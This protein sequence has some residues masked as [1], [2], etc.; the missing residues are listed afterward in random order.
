MAKALIVIPARM[1]STRFSGK[2]MAVIAGKSMIERVWRIAKA[3]PSAARAIIA[4]DDAEL[5]TFCETF[6][7]E[8]MMT[9]PEC[10]TGTDRVAEVAAALPDYDIIFN[11]QGDAVLTPPAVIET[12]IQA[13]QADLAAPVG[14]PVVHLK[15]EALEGFLEKKKAGSTTGTTAVF[16]LNGYALYFSK[17]VIPNVRGK[18]EHPPIFKHVGL[19]AYRREALAKLASLPEGR[20]EKA[21]KLEQ[22]RALENGIRIACVEV[23]LGGRTMASVDNPEDVAQVESIIAKEGELL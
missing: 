12:L 21:E 11:F 23:E 2:P 13:M 14:T 16:D 8:V 6:G 22:L 20:F 7:A 9:S 10:A 4:T 3:V 17:A 15:G 19:Y 5:K 18:M 1:S